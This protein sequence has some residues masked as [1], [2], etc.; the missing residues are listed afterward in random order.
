LRQD[1]DGSQM[2]HYPGLTSQP[3]HDPVQFPLVRALES[4]AE[5]I[6]REAV[7]ID[8]NA[9]HRETEPISRTGD[10]DVFFLYDRGRRNEANCAACPVTAQLIEENRTVRD[11]AGL[12]YFS[13]MAPGTRVAPHRGPTNMRLR[14]HLGIE[15]PPEC[16]MRVAGESRSWEAGKCLVFDDSFPHEVW[17]DSIFARTVLVVDLWHPDLSEDELR[18]LQGLQRYAAGHGRQA[19][20]SWALNEAAS[21]IR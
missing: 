6:A 12:A 2:L 7:A 8:S 3:W 1:G 13:R 5:Q 15:I 4:S 10:W 19:A 14:C 16:G 9:F 20:R 17:N 21:A 18:L 11:L